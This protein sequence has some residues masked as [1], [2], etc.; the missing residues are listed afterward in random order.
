MVSLET[1]LLES[2]GGADA[3]PV[4]E[5]LSELLAALIINSADP[6]HLSG[7]G[8]KKAW[9]DA[10]LD[11]PCVR[12]Y[13][14]RVASLKARDHPGLSNK[15]VFKHMDIRDALAKLSAETS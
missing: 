10:W 15:A 5:E 9:L 13:T 3:A 11:K 8:A 4:N 6:G 12:E 7:R 2:L 1:R 14:D